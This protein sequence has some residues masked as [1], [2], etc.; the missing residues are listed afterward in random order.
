MN[1]IYTLT[2]NP[3]EINFSPSTTIEE[4]LQNVNTIVTTSKFSVPLFREFGV[5]AS[6]LDEPT[7]LVKSKMVAEITEKV[8]FFEERV[9][10]EQISIESN[11]DGRMIPTLQISIRQGVKITW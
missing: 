8:E 6:F 9:I 4:I 3:A 5:D 2:V 10:V 7:P 1:Q 11:N